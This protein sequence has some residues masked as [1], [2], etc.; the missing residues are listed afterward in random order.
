MKSS[1][2]Q[3]NFVD[4]DIILQ[5]MKIQLHKW[6]CLLESGHKRMGW[7]IGFNAIPDQER[8]KLASPIVGFL[9]SESV[10][11]SGSTYKIKKGTK[12][13]IEAEVAILIGKD[14]PAASNK[15]QLVDA[16]EGFAPAI[17]LV[18]VARTTHD[19]SSILED[20]IFHEKVILG[21]VSKDMPGLTAKDISANVYVN[22]QEVQ[23]GDSSR[24]PD[25]FSEIVSVVADTLA[26]QGSFLQA[27]DWIISGSITKPSEVFADD[28]IEVA[29][30]PLG[31]LT[32]SIV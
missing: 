20:N 21:K 13:M 4:E 10:L 23:T 12:L 16:I 8:M 25:D 27:G 22:S 24:Y 1:T 6:Q 5:A 15:T 26:K 18:D 14:V 29:L 11:D 9:T 31:S 30:S 28:H 17:E 32:V 7:K 3:N 19:I 2:T